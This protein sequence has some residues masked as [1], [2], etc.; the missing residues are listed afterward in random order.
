MNLIDALCK[1][2]NAPFVWTPGTI[3]WCRDC[4]LK[5]VQGSHIHPTY[6]AHIPQKEERN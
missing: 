4:K 1:K 5:E 3:A 2:C 6:T